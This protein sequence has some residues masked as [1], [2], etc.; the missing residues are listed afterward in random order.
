M[1]IDIFIK[2]YPAD[3]KWLKY[4]LQSITKFVAE[5]DKIHIVVPPGAAISMTNEGI[6]LPY[7]TNIHI[8]KDQCNG[9][10]FQ[11][12]CK[13]IAHHYSDADY[14][15]FGDSDCLFYK[16]IN[17]QELIATGKPTILHT[18]WKDVGDAICWKQPTEKVFDREVPA[19]FMRRNGLVYHRSTLEKFQE[20]F[21]K[22][23]ACSLLEYFM[24][25]DRI[26]EFNLLGAYAWFYE[27]DKYHW[28]D[29]SKEEFGPAIVRQFWSHSGLNENDFQ[30]IN[31]ILK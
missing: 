13:L 29:T 17:L 16:P 3:Y 14:I 28:I 26:S 10:I 20:W 24:K 11:Q 31:E 15:L 25:I 5:Y 18:P 2:S 19:E 8:L 1:K 27:P 6:E 7:N 30:E 22:R 21:E 9:Y 4:C 12:Y 23:F